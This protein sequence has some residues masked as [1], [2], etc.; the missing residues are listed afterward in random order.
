MI[1]HWSYTLHQNKQKRKGK[2]KKQNR[3]KKAPDF[4]ENLNSR[5]ELVPLE[6]MQR[7]PCVS[8][9]HPSSRS[10]TLKISSTS[11]TFLQPDSGFF[12]Q[13]V[14]FSE[15]FSCIPTAPHLL[16]RGWLSAQQKLLPPGQQCPNPI[17][18]TVLLHTL[19][20]TESMLMTCTIYH[21]FMLDPLQRECCYK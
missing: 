15:L 1:S 2:K 18:S 3:G 13:R 12:C 17:G 21:W 4:G 7:C 16:S 9:G 10:S 6:D 5:K 19:P 20:G 14:P 8:K 11:Q